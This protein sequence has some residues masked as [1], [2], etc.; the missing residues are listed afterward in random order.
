[1]VWPRNKSKK[2]TT[3]VQ[4]TTFDDADFI[5]LFSPGENAKIIKQD[6][7]NSIGVTGTILSIGDP[8]AT[9]VLITSGSDNEIRSI[10]PGVGIN[11]SVTALG[12]IEVDTDLLPASGG[13][14]VLINESTAP[15]IRA[16]EAGT[17]I[18]ITTGGSGDTLIISSTDS[19]T[20]PPSDVVV[21]NTLADLPP[22]SGGVRTLGSNLQYLINNDLTLDVPLVFGDFTVLTGVDSFI[23]TL[24]YSGSGSML[25][26]IDVDMKVRDIR[27]DCPNAQIFE[28]TSNANDQSIV[29]NDVL[30]F[31]CDSIGTF[32]GSQ[33]V[34]SEGCIFIAANGGFTFTDSHDAI[35][36]EKF[37][38]AVTT[39]GSMFDLGT[40]VSD[41][42]L[43]ENAIIT[44]L[45]GT[46]FMTGATGS[47][48]LSSNGFGI[49]NNI[50]TAGGGAV[51]SGISPQDARWR[52]NA[53]TQ[54][55][56][57]VPGALIS[58]DADTLVTIT[59]VGTPVQV[60]GAWSVVR[61]SQY[62]GNING[63]IDYDGPSQRPAIVSATM[64]LD[65]IGPNNQQLTA[66]LAKNGTVLTGSG[67]DI[68]VDSDD[69]L[70]VTVVYDE[71]VSTSDT[72]SLWVQNNTSTANINVEAGSFRVS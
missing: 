71:F 22:E 70:P 1:M 24:T 7:I 59:A 40:T 25:Q 18:A 10:L 55:S 68:E 49:V 64:T 34:A 45:P 39:S 61:N 20:P 9:P 27:I 36:I 54:I 66:F 28:H 53:N 57:T 62:T 65:P 14:Q 16:L 72:L 38:G 3:F 2:Q 42:F 47:A 13:A 29:F 19:P 37:Q 17:G 63:T 44:V 67:V 21:V 32:N 60:G 58:L 56:D 26:G 6:F 4:K 50:R 52:F 12:S 35:N 41:Y 46:T 51:L 15:Q 30:C 5:A 33:I 23:T 43:V 69:P 48:N 11:V 31:N 8:S